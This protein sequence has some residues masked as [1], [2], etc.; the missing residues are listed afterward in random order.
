MPAMTT[1]RTISTAVALATLALASLSAQSNPAL[2]SA[3][4]A[5]TPSGVVHDGRTVRPATQAA[6]V[7]RHAYRWPIKPFGRQHPVRGLFGDPRIANQGQSRQFHFGI[8]I[9]ARNGTPVY[10]TASGRIWIHPLHATTVVVSAGNGIEHSYW[11]VVPVVRTGDRA[12][13]Y[14]TVLGH[15]EAPYGH[16]HFSESRHGRYLNPLRPGALGPYADHTRPQVLSVELTNDAVVAQ[17]ADETPL[18]VPRPWHDLPVMPALV[19]WRLLDRGGRAVSG[20]NVLVDF[21]STIPAASE[22]DRIWAPGAMQNRV[23]APGRYR[24]P[25]RSLDPRAIRGRQ[26]EVAVSDTRGN[27]SRRRFA[28]VELLSRS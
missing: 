10:A 3:E 19:R 1:S 20:W 5:P 22:F 6:P 9:S 13:A 18:A 28:G 16:V 23:R 21:R 7:Q 2:S 11:H 8:D 4:A 27:A 12:V 15:I 26:V 24:L 14:R 17:V 25:L